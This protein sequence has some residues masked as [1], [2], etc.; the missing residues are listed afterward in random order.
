MNCPRCSW[1]SEDWHKLCRICSYPLHKSYDANV[2][3]I[4]TKTKEANK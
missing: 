3:N 4:W 2:V 1:K